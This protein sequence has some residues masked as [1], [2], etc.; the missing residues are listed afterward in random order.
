M[1]GQEDLMREREEKRKKAIDFFKRFRPFNLF[2]G[3]GFP[4]SGGDLDGEVGRR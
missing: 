2:R 4:S 3:G 1:G